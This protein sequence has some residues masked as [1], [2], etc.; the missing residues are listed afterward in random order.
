MKFDA[1]FNVHKNKS[2]AA[3]KFASDPNNWK[4]NGILYERMR[5]QIFTNLTHLL[6]DYSR[7]VKLIAFL[8]RNIF[9]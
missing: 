6:T 1:D 9:K 5:Q 2:G 4:K 7:Q 3:I 8:R